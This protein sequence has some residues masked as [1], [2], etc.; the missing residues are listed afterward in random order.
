MGD[1]RAV[2]RLV[3]RLESHLGDPSVA[4][5]LLS[6]SKALQHDDSESLNHAALNHLLAWDFHSYQ[7]PAT[8]GGKAVDIQD[9]LELFRV[10]ARRDASVATSL[11]TTSLSF[12]PVWVAGTDGQKEQWVRRVVSGA[13]FGWGLSEENHGSD[14]VANEASARRVEGGFVLNGEKWPIGNSAVGEVLTV[15]ARTGVRPGPAAFSVLMVDRRCVPA[16]SVRPGARLRLHG[17]KA[18]DNGGVGFH[19]CFVS[20]DA[21]IGA[22][23]QGLEIALKA[24]L[25]VRALAPAM[26]LGCA[27]TGLRLALKFATTR[28]IFG[29][30]LVAV[31]YTRRALVEA[32]ADLLV[33]DAVATGAARLLQVR[34]SQSSIS[35][36]VSKYLVPI[37]LE[38]TMSA[39]S[40]VLG[41]RHYV[42]SDPEY[43]VFHKMVRDLWISHFAEGNTVV[44]L[45][46]I[47]SHLPTLLGKAISQDDRVVEE[48]CSTVDVAFDL[49]APLPAFE[50]R[51]LD[52]RSR[53]GDDVVSAMP[54]LIERL[55]HHAAHA[56]TGDAA[57]LLEAGATASKLYG[58]LSSML[59]DLNEL[60]ETHGSHWTK[61]E[62]SYR[63]AERYAL[64][65]G[66][67]A[68]LALAVTSRDHS[69]SVVLEAPVLVMC[70]ARVWQQF[71]PLDI[72]V[73]ER[74]VASAADVMLKLYDSSRLFSHR[75]L[76][77]RTDR[78]SLGEP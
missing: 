23:G 61:A 70:L 72:R 11:A 50:P 37:V 73:D 39:L 56:E 57:Y 5:E 29:G 3:D 47:A 38:R 64:I 15:V 6:W 4:T 13:F 9:S 45:K 31:P 41:A 16:A 21:L 14:I 1:I 63:L 65:H 34:P 30:T 46:N 17:L 35:S 40:T 66:A 33:C 55:R 75:R 68:V 59:S 12:M 28:E 78:V 60:R 2:E 32:F 24:A 53:T 26:A 20:E 27:D 19:D 54:A 71:A 44:N 74:V 7:V 25:A 77:V 58:H 18:I 43:G 67:A 51:L 76:Q 62:A 10:V 8:H 48:A 52:M 69:S 22:E 36:S 42:R 49:D